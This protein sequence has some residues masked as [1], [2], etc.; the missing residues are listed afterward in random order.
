LTWNNIINVVE[1]VFVEGASFYK[2]GNVNT[3]AFCKTESACSTDKER[4]EEMMKRVEVNDAGAM[5]F[6][7]S[8][9]RRGGKGGFMQD[10]EKA[11]ELLNR[12]A[13]LGSKEAHFRLG[14]IY[15]GGDPKKETGNDYRR[16]GELKKAKFHYEAAAMAGHELARLNI[17]I[18]E[19]ESGNRE[20]AVKHWIIAASAGQYNAMYNLMIL[21]KHGQLSTNAIEAPLTAYNNSCAE[22]RSEARDAYI[23]YGGPGQGGE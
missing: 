9:Y 10:Q 15:S 12:A 21:Y 19:N 17:G 1:R 22:M 13:K 5:S 11:K 6:M 3:C 18:I 8:Y 20:R 7:G 16:E 4:V 14:N 23:L 2:S